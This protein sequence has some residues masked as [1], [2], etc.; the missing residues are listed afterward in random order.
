MYYIS[1]HCEQYQCA[2]WT[3][4]VCI[5]YYISV[6]C[7]HYQCAL[8]TISVCIVNNIS[9]HCVLYQCALCTISVCIVNNISV[10]CEQ[11]QCALWT[12][13]VC[14]VN[15]ISV[16]CEQY[17]YALWTI[18]VCI[19]NN[20]SVHC[21]QYWIRWRKLSSFNFVYRWLLFSTL[22]IGPMDNYFIQSNI[23]RY[24]FQIGKTFVEHCIDYR[25]F[26]DKIWNKGSTHMK[27]YHYLKKVNNP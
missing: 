3:I 2:L 27:D 6:H 13:S 5:V 15:N 10:H 17:Q 25:Q 11:Y 7:E 19:V 9:V 22:F 8:C 21:E 24:T 4:S 14:I 16:H 1:V 12:I 20:I 18:S 23:Y 26:Q